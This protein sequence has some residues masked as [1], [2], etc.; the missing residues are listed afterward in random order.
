VASEET[1][2]FTPDE[3]SA[4]LPEVDELL[5]RAHELLEK[6]RR[7]NS[8]EA[9]RT[10]GHVRVGGPP[11]QRERVRDLEQELGTVVRRV[12]A[13][14]IIVRDLGTGL[15]DFP[16]LRDGVEVYLCW[17]RG[18]PHRI[19]WWHPTHTGVAGRRPL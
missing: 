11:S 2:Y 6:I 1:R 13:H 7:T 14:G 8:T 19:Q 4:L 9:A 15:I 5:R 10:N 16:S 3:A 12:Q 18:E 17:R